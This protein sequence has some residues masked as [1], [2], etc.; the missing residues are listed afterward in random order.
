MGAFQSQ[1][2]KCRYALRWYFRLVYGQR[3]KSGY[4]KE[5][6]RGTRNEGVEEGRKVGEI[7]SRT[8]EK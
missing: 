8:V 4:E 1:V 2:K 7:M 3:L 5:W 6:R